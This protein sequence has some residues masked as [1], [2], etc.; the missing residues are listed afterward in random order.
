MAKKKKENTG[1]WLV[2]VKVT[3]VRECLFEDCTEE[4]AKSCDW[5]K[6]VDEGQ[7]MQMTDWEVL[8]VKPNE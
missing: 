7:D 3:V 8:S 1:S 4:E 6:C 5:S 2:E